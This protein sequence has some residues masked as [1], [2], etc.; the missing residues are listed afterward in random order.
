MRDGLRAMYTGREAIISGF[1]TLRGDVPY[2]SVWCRGNMLG[3]YNGDDLDA[4]T[5]MLL[6]L[7]S[8]AEQNDNT[9]IFI[10]KIHP[11][12]KK[13]YVSS[14]SDVIATLP[15][16]M[17]ELDGGDDS[18]AG[19]QTDSKGMLPYST[20]FLLKGQTD[21]MQKIVDSNAAI[22]ARI[23][24][25]EKPGEKELD[26]FDRIGAILDK[27]G[28]TDLIGKLLDKLQLFPQ[29][30]PN[31]MVSGV[32]GAGSVIAENIVDGQPL[33]QPETSASIEEKSDAAIDFTDEENDKI[34]AAIMRLSGHCDVVKSLVLMADYADANPDTFKWVLGSLKV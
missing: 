11:Q 2:F 22:E 1:K 8:A 9:D 29:A 4:G 26:T 21:A 17:I 13:G 28:V 6:Q 12:L 7:I 3:Q 23:A 14:S 10:I 34:D 15:V 25:L 32:K 24:L 18:I 5:E 20:H 16:R 31:I 27:P 30:Q 33:Q 19:L